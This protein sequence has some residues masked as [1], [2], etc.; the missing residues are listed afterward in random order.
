MRKLWDHYE[1]LDLNQGADEDV[2]PVPAQV[3]PPKKSLK[4]RFE[5]FFFPL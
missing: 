2:T 3:P 1:P 5:G 4:E